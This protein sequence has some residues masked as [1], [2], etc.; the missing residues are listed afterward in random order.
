[1]KEEVA[2]VQVED[3]KNLH[4]TIA[5]ARKPKPTESLRFV[6]VVIGM[7][8]AG[9]TASGVV[10]AA[11]P[12]T[13]NSPTGTSALIERGRYL[14]KITGC[15][16]CHTAGYAASGGKVSQSE[17]LTGDSLGY[18]GAWGTTYP[19]NLRQY[20]ANLSEAEWL[21]IAKGKEMRPPMPYFNLRA[22]TD[23]D[24]RALFRFIRSLQV[25]GDPAPQY[26]PPTQEPKPPYILWPSAPK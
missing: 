11:N 21:V 14:V 23:T 22:M 2:K 3:S 16:D 9:L 13:A 25:K 24:L 17:W 8:I 26:V 10:L 1:M 4:A 18:R 5:V 7:A 15:N 19:M 20:M 6:R 12:P